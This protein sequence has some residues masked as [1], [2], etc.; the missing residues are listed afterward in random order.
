MGQYGATI[1]RRFVRHSWGSVT[2]RVKPSVG[3]LGCPLIFGVRRSFPVEYPVSDA[4]QSHEMRP[5]DRQV[6]NVPVTQSAGR[7]RLRPA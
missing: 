7:Q 2:M 4:Q 1:C 6:T 3:R 5:I